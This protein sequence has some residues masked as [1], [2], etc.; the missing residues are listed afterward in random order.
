MSV[1]AI[2]HVARPQVYLHRLPAGEDRRI[3]HRAECAH[4]RW[5]YENTVKTDV[6]QH[7]QMHRHAHRAA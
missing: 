3:R 2:T 4:C 5:V 6:E 1:P 7:A